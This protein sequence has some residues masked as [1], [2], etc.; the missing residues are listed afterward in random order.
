VV[1][2]FGLL[3]SRIDA[4]EIAPRQNG[5][6]LDLGRI[7]NPRGILTGLELTLI[8]GRFR[9]LGGQKMCEEEMVEK[10]KKSKSGPLNRAKKIKPAEKI[11][12][13]RK[14]LLDMKEKLLA[15]GLGKSLA[16]DLARPFDI[17]DEGDRADTERTHEVSIL[18]SARDK[19][20]LLAIEEALEKL[21]EGTYGM[22]E[23]CGDEIG[24]ERLKAMVMAKLCVPC[25]SRLEKEQVHQKFAEEELDQ[26]LINEGA[27]EERD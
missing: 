24:P 7:K 17:G 4:V 3:S 15:E 19:E 5:E 11:M 12:A 6:R 10:S 2:S 13:A 18:L 25:Q 26:S 20:K 23:E 8:P 22:C 27:G 14:S 1:G 16:E 21:R 9:I